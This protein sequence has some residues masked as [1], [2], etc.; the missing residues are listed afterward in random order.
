VNFPFVEYENE[1]PNKIIKPLHLGHDD[2]TKIYDHGA[3]WVIRINKLKNKYINPKNVLFTLSGPDEH[4]NRLQAYHEI[5][6]ELID[7]GVRVTTVD[8]EDDIIDFVL[9]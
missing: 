1:K 2:S 4:S 8:K 5:E 3:S 7:T 6:K 9:N